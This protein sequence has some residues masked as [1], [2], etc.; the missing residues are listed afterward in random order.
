MLAAKL[1]GDAIDHMEHI[2]RIA[3]MKDAPHYAKDL[4][5]AEWQAITKAYQYVKDYEQKYT[6]TEDHCEATALFLQI[7][8]EDYEEMKEDYEGFLK[9]HKSNP[10]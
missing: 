7:S 5:S 6:C 8:C 1:L 10:Y 4:A 9:H 3:R 2:L